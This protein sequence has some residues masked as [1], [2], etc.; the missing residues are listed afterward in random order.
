MVGYLAI[1]Y[2]LFTD[3]FIFGES[4]SHTELFG[5]AFVV[6]V[7]LVLGFYRMTA[8]KSQKTN[9]DMEE[10]L[11]SQNTSL[12]FLNEKLLSNKLNQDTKR[13]EQSVISKRSSNYLCQYNEFIDHSMNVAEVPTSNPI[14]FRGLGHYQ[15]AMEMFRRERSLSANTFSC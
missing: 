11:E 4:L 5:C 13:K 7:T 1:V 3:L 15:S 14:R 6:S 8:A 12:K 2:A 9:T 10:D